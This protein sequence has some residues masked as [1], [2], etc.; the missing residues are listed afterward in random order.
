MSSSSSLPAVRDAV[1]APSPPMSRLRPW[2]ASSS[3]LQTPPRRRRIT[4]TTVG[5]TNRR[6]RTNASLDSHEP[7]GVAPEPIFTWKFTAEGLTTGLFFCFFFLLFICLLIFIY[8]RHHSETSTL[9]YNRF[10]GIGKRPIHIQHVQH[11][12]LFN[13]EKSLYGE[14]LQNV[15]FEELLDVLNESSLSTSST[16]LYSNTEIFKSHSIR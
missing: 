1:P 11:R 4:T 7:S 15:H 12:V 16:S 3:P 5:Q 6:T 2:P 14:G 10:N 13:T 9:W 8:F